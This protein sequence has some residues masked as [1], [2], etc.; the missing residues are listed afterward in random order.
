MRQTAFAGRKCPCGEKGVFLT[1]KAIFVL[2]A[3]VWIA[4]A[5]GFLYLFLRDGTSV[6][7][8]IAIL[9]GM[10]NCLWLTYG[11]DLMKK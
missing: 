6:Y 1:K 2:A 9:C 8:A 5:A 4:G 7:G 11:R 10:A 3:L